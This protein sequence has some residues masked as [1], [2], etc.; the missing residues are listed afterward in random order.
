MHIFL[1]RSFVFT[2]KNDD[3]NRMNITPK[4]LHQWEYNLFYTIKN[5]SDL[6]YQRLAWTGKLTGVVSSYSEIIN[7]LF[8][9]FELEEYINYIKDQ[10][11]KKLLHQA[12]TELVI[13]LNS[14]KPFSNDKLILQDPN[15]EKI[16]QKAQDISSLEIVIASLRKD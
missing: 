3:I 6:N 13:D 7:M 16:T 12:L 9:D 15:W 5:L 2:K 1:E 11:K 10:P 14:Y 8:D 4:D